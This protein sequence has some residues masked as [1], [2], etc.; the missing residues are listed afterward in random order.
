MKVGPAEQL[1]MLCLLGCEAECLEN[2][3]GSQAE[4]ELQNAADPVD[5]I[6]KDVIGFS[7]LDRQAERAGFSVAATVVIACQQLEHRG[8]RGGTA[9]Y[10]HYSVVRTTVGI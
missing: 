8:I 6:H 9:E 1:Q 3:S 4:I 2:S 7:D 5:T 10:G